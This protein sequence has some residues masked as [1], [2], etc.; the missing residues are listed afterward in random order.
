MG[1][2]I[3]IWGNGK[4]ATPSR[5]S[6]RA[7]T[8]Q[9]SRSAPALVRETGGGPSADVPPRPALPVDSNLALGGGEGGEVGARDSKCHT[10]DGLDRVVVGGA[11][12]TGGGVVGGGDVIDAALIH[13]RP[14]ASQH[15]CGDRNALQEAAAGDARTGAAAT[16]F[17]YGVAR[18][19]T[20]SSASDEEDFM[21]PEELIKS[22]SSDEEAGGVETAR[23]SK[24]PTSVDP[25][26]AAIAADDGRRD[27][28]MD[29]VTPPATDVRVGVRAAV[30]NVFTCA[31]HL[32]AYLLLRGQEDVTQQQY[33]V[34]RAGFNIASPVKLPSANHICYEISPTIERERML[35]TS[36]CWAP[37]VGKDGLV[38]VKYI[39]PSEHV[40]R[41]LMFE[42][43][44]ELFKEAEARTDLDREL[45]P[46]FVDSPLFQDRSSVL[47]GGQTVQKF[48]LAS[49]DIA[50][51]DRLDVD[52]GSG[53]VVRG[54][55]V[56]DAF[57]V[58]SA[59]GLEPDDGH[60][61]G[62]FLVQCGGIEDGAPADIWARHW[63]A[64]SLHQLS[65]LTHDGNAALILSLHH[66][67]DHGLPPH[68][69]RCAEHAGASSAADQQRA[70]DIATAAAAR[71]GDM[72]PTPAPVDVE[73]PLEDR[74]ASREA[75][76]N[77]SGA[78]RSLTRRVLSGTSD[79]MAYLVVCLCI[80]SDDFR[81]RL[82]KEIS[83][84]GVYMSYLSWLFRRRR[85][86]HAVRTLAATPPDVDSDVV[87]EA[88]TPDLRVGATDGWLMVGA[89]GSDV[90]VFADVCFTWA[91]TCK[92]PR[93]VSP[94]SQQSMH[95]VFLSA[96]GSAWMSIRSSWC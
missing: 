30:T 49:L 37:Q 54:V 82:G 25:S 83:L 17:L 76:L 44:S 61:A 21:L 88:I 31:E 86:S 50:I 19:G 65:C 59:S 68:D 52:L 71:Q 93:Q 81:A 75:D 80:F 9:G 74:D 47:Q 55:V 20:G 8:R 46:E 14:A 3:A 24:D 96:L 27:D 2:A 85:S 12:P 29:G 40:Q 72:R 1:R 69:G 26:H 43:T 15:R 60:H 94:R 79:G 62:D 41:D 95:H 89:D 10:S 48:A 67:K 63:H 36:T 77:P 38:E 13:G 87:L 42:R 57:F 34:N 90:R 18:A 33:N 66:H 32:Y 16:D 35:Q 73:E 6:Q 92:W 23:P 7:A 4:R 84:G 28:A 78:G 22:V 45:H 11:S 39:K 58:G 64:A 56:H 70:E 5:R 51:G 53:R 91:T